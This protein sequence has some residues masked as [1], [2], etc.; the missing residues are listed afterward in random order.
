MEKNLNIAVLI[1]ITRVLED[2]NTVSIK[3]KLNF[4]LPDLHSNTCNSVEHSYSVSHLMI[5]NTASHSGNGI[6]WSTGLIVPYEKFVLPGY[7]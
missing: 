2:L 7:C 4:F 6:M 5:E 1:E 3:Q